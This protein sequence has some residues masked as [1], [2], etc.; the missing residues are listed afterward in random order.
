MDWHWIHAFLHNSCGGAEYFTNDHTGN[1]TDQ[2]DEAKS[3]R[4]EKSRDAGD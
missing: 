3:V 2:R 1:V 4:A